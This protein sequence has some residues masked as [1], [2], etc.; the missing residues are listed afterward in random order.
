MEFWF[1]EKCGQRVSEKELAAG[2]YRSPDTGVAYCIKC[3]PAITSQAPA[4]AP[5]AA[6]APAVAALSVPVASTKPRT[7]PASGSM[8]KTRTTP[9][10]GNSPATP[11][12]GRAVPQRT[13]GI[14]VRETT[15]LRPQQKRE[16]SSGRP[17]PSD[18]SAAGTDSGGRKNLPLILGGG[19]VA[20]LLIVGIFLMTSSPTKQTASTTTNATNAASTPSTTAHQDT[21]SPPAPAHVPDAPPATTAARTPAPP[22]LSQ[23]EVLNEEAKAQD[24]FSTLEKKLKTL[25]DQES[26]LT[27][28]DTFLKSYGETIVGSR[29]RALRSKL[30]SGPLETQAP[31]PPAPPAPVA[32]TPAPAPAQNG[33]DPN[34]IVN[35]ANALFAK[36]DYAGTIAEYD[37]AIKSDDHQYIFFQNRA[38]A[39]V[40]VSDY[41]GVMS[42]TE[43]AIALEPNSWGAWGLRAI[44]AFGLN[45]LDEYHVSL[46]KAATL[47]GATLKQMEQ[48]IAVDAQRAR[49]TVDGKGFETKAPSTGEEFRMR[50]M[51][52]LAVGKTAECAADLREALKRDPALGSKGI[53]LDLTN[54]ARARKDL[55]EVMTY[56]K[57]WS[58][59]KPEDPVGLNAYAWELLTCED[60]A[61]RDAKAALPLSER[62]AE[63]TQKKDAAILDTLALA[64]F[65]NNRVRTAVAMEQKA[66]ALLPAD[67]TPEARK[68]YEKHLSDFQAIEGKDGN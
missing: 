60:V 23:R 62:A 4:T 28:V 18:R 12:S 59:I 39:K 26:Q 38:N 65:S 32:H 47:S 21:P 48:R 51:Y 37:R 9:I 25:S 10:R 6:A 56:M 68:D 11:A 17:Q 27:A 46:E 53:Y 35:R 40:A 31:A 64:Y 44:A 57:Q 61:L 50:A 66:I 3:T 54:L 7:T 24:A 34:A 2:A 36:Q 8:P 49:W 15:I 30:K 41:D 58:E 52:R 45:R 29:A 42:D 33:D 55:K 14:R 16:T 43:K 1:C 5:A 20:A 22:A 63:L 67:T 19:S 13:T